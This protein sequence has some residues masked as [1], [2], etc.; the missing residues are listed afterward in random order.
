MGEPPCFA[1]LTADSILGPYE[2]VNPKVNPCGLEVGDFDLQVDPDTEKGYLIS[3][4]P[5]TCIYVAEL[6]EDYTDAAGTYTEHF[7]HTAPPQAREAPAHFIRNG[8]HYLITSGTTGYDSNPS[9]ASIAADWNGPYEVLGDPHVND[10]SKTSFNSQITS[11]FRHPGK[12]DLYIAL[13]DRWKP[14]ICQMEGYETGAY[15]DRIQEKFRRIFDPK[16]EFVFTAEDAADMKI[17]S[18][19]SDYVWLPL[20]FEGGQVRIE[21][22]DEWTI[23][24]YE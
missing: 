14:E 6:N 17:N 2:M 23:E 20:K 7:P 12:K 13:A 22:R 21:W 10:S 16:V 11:V 24:E 4:K 1:V 3:Q 19:V 18:S 15:S 8:L 9:E 5:H